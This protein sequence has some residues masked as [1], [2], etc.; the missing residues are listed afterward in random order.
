MNRYN[1]WRDIWEIAAVS[2]LVTC[3]NPE[4]CLP[5]MYLVYFFIP[6]H[7]DLITLFSRKSYYKTHT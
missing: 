3:P 5:C 4:K 1:T 6:G 7:Y 2:A